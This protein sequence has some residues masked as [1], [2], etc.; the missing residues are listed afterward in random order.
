MTDQNINLD[1]Q[2]LTTIFDFAE[3]SQI[4]KVQVL[5]PL[6]ENPCLMNISKGFVLLKRSF[7]AVCVPHQPCIAFAGCSSIR[8]DSLC[9]C[10]ISTDVQVS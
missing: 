10:S 9:H 6:Q 8:K 1:F 4:K 7:G 3:F 5:L 2:Q